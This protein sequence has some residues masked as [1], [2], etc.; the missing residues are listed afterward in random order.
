MHS[1]S[2]ISP[3]I[4]IRHAFLRTP[5]YELPPFTHPSLPPV[6]PYSDVK[7]RLLVSASQPTPDLR[8][9]FIVRS[10]T[11]KPHTFF[12]IAWLIFY[13]PAQQFW[14]RCM[15]GR[16]ENTPDGPSAACGP[17]ATLSSLG[18]FG[19]GQV[20]EFEELSPVF[21]QFLDLVQ[22]VMGQFPTAFE[23]TEGLLAFVAEHA[24]RCDVFWCGVIGEV[25]P[26]AEGWVGG[27]GAGL[28]P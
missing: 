4:S 26:R 27:G 22:N 12:F 20:K 17:S 5:L 7:T 10:N 18:G 8:R 16:A 15:G 28:L 24:F 14:S 3:I 13:P 19:G 6:P 23:F 2:P 11:F 21:L 9:F 25:G 1:S